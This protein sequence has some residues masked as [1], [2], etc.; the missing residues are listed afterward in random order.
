LELILRDL[1]GTNPGKEIGYH[2]VFLGFSV[3]IKRLIMKKK[4]W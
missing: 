3:G 2:S 1:G 4:T